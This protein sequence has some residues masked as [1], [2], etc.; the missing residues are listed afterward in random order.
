MNPQLERYRL[1]VN[2]PGATGPEHL[3][4]LVRRD[5][6][7]KIE[8]SLSP[9]QLEVLQ[10]ADRTFLRHAT[11]FYVELAKGID[12]P[13]ERQEENIPPE[14]WWWYLDVLAQLP[15]QPTPAPT[16][17]KKPTSS[18]EEAHAVAS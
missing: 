10:E 13:A 17:E 11:L 8:S 16:E 4:M 12:F 6:L 1:E 2:D 18:E 5:N 7:A 14:R 3:Q 15:Q 9:E